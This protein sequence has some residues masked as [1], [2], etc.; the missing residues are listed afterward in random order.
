MHEVCYPPLIVILGPTACGKS[1]LALS[2]SLSIDGEI[3]SADSRQI[4]KEL[5][6]GT[7]KPSLSDRLLVPHHLVDIINPGEDFTLYDFQHMAM[8]AILDVY[9]RGKRPLLVGGTGL[10]I[11]AV[12]EGLVLPV[13]SPDY[14]Y[15]TYLRALAGEK[16]TKYLH[17]MLSDVDREA[18]E[19]I[20]HNDLRR[21][22]RALEVFK[23][24]SVT[25]SG[26][27]KNREILP[28]KSMKFGINWPRETLYRLIEERVDTMFSSGLVDEVRRLMEKGYSFEGP[29]LDAVGYA[30]TADYLKGKST[31]SEA[32]RLIKR[33][34]RHFSKRQMTW[35]RKD[36]DIVWF[37]PEKGI[38]K[39][40]MVKEIVGMVKSE[41]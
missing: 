18:S 3:I 8:E 2:L 23:T 4:Y 19:R 30:E 9:R 24:G 33:N 39:E 5:L 29:P 36:K 17:E 41:G 26:L 1:D 25:M 6:I 22:V 28:F 10:Y 38:S 40:D 37:E 14:E 21:L 35:F 12:T 27:Q 11:K 15:R 16:G 7:A 31:M 20:H 34:T 32:L 13:T